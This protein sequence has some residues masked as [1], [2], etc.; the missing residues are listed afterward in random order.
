MSDQNIST[1]SQHTKEDDSKPIWLIL[2]LLV[3]VILAY[4]NTLQSPFVY[5]DKIEVIGNETIR[6]WGKW[7]EIA[8]YNPSRMLLLFSYA[9]NFHLDQFNPQVYHQY[10]IA[11]H[12]CS[13]FSVFFLFDRLSHYFKKPNPKYLAVIIT[14]IWSLH[15]MVTESVTYITGRSESLCLLF[16][17]LSLGLWTHALLTK[18]WSFRLLSFLALLCSCLTKEVG[19][20]TMFPILY[21]EFLNTD[22]RK[23]YLWLTPLSILI[24]SLVCPLV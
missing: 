23:S 10:N 2:I 15:P 7:K 20:M 9:Y 14:G 11:I 16:S 21:L 8:S 4:S 24:L 19:L 6:D 12:I 1:T 22:K 3:L 17:T 13:F 18:Q 5:D